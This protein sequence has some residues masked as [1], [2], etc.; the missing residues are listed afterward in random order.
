MTYVPHIIHFN[1]IPYF[2]LQTQYM[3]AEDINI[4]IGAVIETFEMT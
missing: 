3:T 4:G 1:L 2:V